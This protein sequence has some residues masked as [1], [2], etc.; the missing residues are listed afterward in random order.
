MDGGEPGGG[1]AGGSGGA[2]VGGEGSVVSVGGQQLLIT[3][4]G[5]DGQGTIMMSAEDAAQFFQ[6]AGIQWDPSGKFSDF[7][8]CWKKGSP[9]IGT[10]FDHSP[11]VCVREIVYTQFILYRH[12]HL[13]V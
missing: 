4:A 13:E 2:A 3:G 6:N 5:S 8:F 12:T 11:V 7:H 9:I 10:T 1:S